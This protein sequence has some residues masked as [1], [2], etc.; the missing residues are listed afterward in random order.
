MSSWV[1]GV[2]VSSEGQARGKGKCRVQSSILH[3]LHSA[4]YWY[5]HTDATQATV[6]TSLEFRETLG[7][8]PQIQQP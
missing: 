3:M 8:E 4:A 2:T 6:F 1:D 5:R 7:L